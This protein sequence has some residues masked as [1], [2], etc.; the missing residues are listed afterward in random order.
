MNDGY[1]WIVDID[2]EKF[3]DTV[4]QDKLITI[5]GKTIT[6]GYVIQKNEKRLQ[7]D[8]L[9]DSMKKYKKNSQKFMYIEN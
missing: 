6:D 5:I 3:F 8:T 7:K 2:L 1:E 9:C 4:N